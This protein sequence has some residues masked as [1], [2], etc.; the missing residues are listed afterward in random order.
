MKKNSMFCLLVVL[1]QFLISNTDENNKTL[2]E[3]KKVESRLE[4]EV[5][6]KQDSLK[7]IRQ[8]ILQIETESIK[9]SFEFKVKTIQS[10]A[11]KLKP[12]IFSE[13]ISGFKENE[14]IKI[15][16]YTSGFWK[17]ERNNIIGYTLGANLQISIALENIKKR[18]DN[19]EKEQRENEKKQ[20]RLE[21]EEK[22]KAKREKELNR[23]KTEFEKGKP[24]NLANTGMWIIKNYVDKFK[25]KT[26]KRYITYKDNIIGNFS[27][28]AT[29]NSP[30]K[31]EIAIDYI[32]NKETP[33]D[34]EPYVSI[35][36]Y[37]Y[38][39]NNPVKSY[40]NDKYTVSIKDKSG[41][42][43]TIEAINSSSDRLSFSNSGSK[44][45][46]YALEKGG[47]LKFVIVEKD[48][49]TSEY[50]FEIKNANNYTNAYYKLLT[51][52]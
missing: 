45:I 32:Y 3:L 23:L 37:E 4:N 29:Q 14:F 52:K 21:K 27:N 22:E 10:G 47:L 42:K 12:D 8:E 51:G 31:V 44:A 20:A 50:Y 30:L 18:I 35:F 25:E 46:H 7:Q 48:T 40:K 16:G 39:G 33:Y 1:I 9:D 28:T 19:E 49:P 17:V 24:Q 6:F 38:A 2:N 5:K 11:I 26:E 34:Y 41:Y 13:A 36:L 43:F 15:I